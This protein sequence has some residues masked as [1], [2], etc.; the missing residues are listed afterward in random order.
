MSIKKDVFENKTIGQ[1]YGLYLSL[2]SEILRE[3]RNSDSIKTL[4]ENKT[5]LKQCPT[6]KDINM[7]DVQDLIY[8]IGG[9]SP[10]SIS[11]SQTNNE[12]EN[13]V[14]PTLLQNDLN[15]ILY[16]PPGTGKTYITRQR[17]VELISPSAVA[18][19]ISVPYPPEVVVSK[20]ER[21][22]RIVKAFSQAKKIWK[23]APGEKEKFRG[24]LLDKWVLGKV[25]AIGLWC[26]DNKDQDLTGKTLPEIRSLA[27]CRGER[28]PYNA[29]QI[30]KF[31]NEMKIDDVVVVYSDKQIRAIAKIK[32]VYQY[33][34]YGAWT[35]IKKSNAT[36]DLKAKLP[37]LPILKEKDPSDALE[38]LRDVEY[39]HYREVEYLER[40][41]IK[42]RGELYKK[43]GK[44]AAFFD[45]SKFRDEIQKL[46]VENIKKEAGD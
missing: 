44:N 34:A 25:I 17:A 39:T 36:A 37:Q 38:F 29:S 5:L 28:H 24:G 14:C 32:E 10:E 23:I 13:E 9:K 31:I 41:E 40:I 2:C 12:R 43:L 20:K 26:D 42:P 33:A 15:I 1:K 35:F 11:P 45:I 30:D 8:L 19:E 16:G 6:Y 27:V 3:L 22:E 7:L 4:K 21:I 18:R 46:V